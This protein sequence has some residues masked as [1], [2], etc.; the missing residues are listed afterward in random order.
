MIQTRL[1]TA[2]K[3]KSKLLDKQP[4]SLFDVSQVSKEGVHC[5][6]VGSVGDCGACVGKALSLAKHLN[7]EY[8]ENFVHMI[9]NDANVGH[10]QFDYDYEGPIYVDKQDKVRAELLFY[11]TSMML[12]LKD[13][14]IRDA[15]FP[16]VEGDDH[17]KEAFLENLHQ[18]LSG[19]TKDTQTSK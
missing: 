1:K 11:K 17:L 2:E 15:Y 8:G 13:G 18:I 5:F 4:V 10:Y 14:V 19:Q 9:T 7:T 12:L 16:L 6:V 3:M